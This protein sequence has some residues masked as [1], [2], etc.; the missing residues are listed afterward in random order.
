[1]LKP[2][3][4]TQPRPRR[5]GQRW[6]KNAFIFYLRISTLKSFTLFITVRTN[7]NLGHSDKFEIKVSSSRFTF[8]RR[9]N[10]S[11]HVV[12]DARGQ[13]L[14]CSL[15]L[16]FRD[17]PLAVTV[18]VFLRPH[19]YGLGYLRQPSPGVTLGELTFT[20]VVVKFK[21]PFIWMTPSGGETIEWTSCLTS[22]GRV[23]LAGGTTFL[24]TWFAWPGPLSA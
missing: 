20:C 17:L 5:Q 21:Q 24:H 15:N 11:F 9:G 3:F 22:A 10:W 7:A 6:L 19:L 1:M 8:S 16:L 18:M 4:I 14:F 2:G 23:T 13:P 12:V